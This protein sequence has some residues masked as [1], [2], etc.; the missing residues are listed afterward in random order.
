MI[1]PLALLDWRVASL[2][3]IWI[4]G[5][6]IVLFYLSLWDFVRCDKGSK[7]GAIFSDRSTKVALALG[8]VVVVT[9]YAIAPKDWGLRTA[10]QGVFV[11]L[12]RYVPGPGEPV[13]MGGGDKPITLDKMEMISSNPT[14]HPGRYPNDERFI[15]MPWN[16]AVGT[17]F[18]RF[19]RGGYEL[20]FEGA[21]TEAG[22]EGARVYVYLVSLENQRLQLEKMLEEIR[23]EKEPKSYSVRFDVAEKM[24]GKVRIQ[25]FNDAG[26]AQGGDRSARIGG[27]RLRKVGEGKWNL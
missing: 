19:A 17:P 2:N 4:A 10:T 27:F 14:E 26:G 13:D 6:A 25:F 23:L 1:V 8:A 7:F 15:I 3:L 9:G 5:I 22:G 18:F 11:D 24:I 12:A 20:S 16:G 21:G